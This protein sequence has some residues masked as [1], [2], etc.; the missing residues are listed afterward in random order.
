MDIT[1]GMCN[2]PEVPEMKKIPEDP[3]PVEEGKNFTVSFGMNTECDD[4]ALSKAVTTSIYMCRICTF[5]CKV[6]N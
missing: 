1:T 3:E 2:S 6:I 4:A 5:F